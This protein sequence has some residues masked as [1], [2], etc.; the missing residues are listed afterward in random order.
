MKTFLLKLFV[1]LLIFIA[2]WFL[3]PVLQ[4]SIDQWPEWLGDT[5]MQFLLSFIAAL[6][7]AFNPVTAR[8]V[9]RVIIKGDDNMVLQGT[10]GSGNNDASI[11]GSRNR[12]KQE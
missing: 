1:M 7:L 10:D 11:N 12:V 2:I 9:N 5:N 4:D 3:N 8:V 6:V